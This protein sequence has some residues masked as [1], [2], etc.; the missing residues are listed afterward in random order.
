MLSF[1]LFMLGLIISLRLI[2]VPL[3]VLI[4]E[5]G[6]LVTALIFAKGKV[7]MSLGLPAGSER[8]RSISVGRVTVDFSPYFFFW[9][10][11]S[12]KFDGATP[13]DKNIIISFSG[14][15]ANM[16]VG[17][18]FIGLAFGFDWH[19]A[20]KWLSLVFL[21]S[22]VMDVLI[23][24]WPR[25]HLPNIEYPNIIGND[26]YSIKMLLKSKAIIRKALPG[27]KELLDV[28]PSALAPEIVSA[29]D[30]E[31]YIY[32]VSFLESVS[33]K[34]YADA[35][36]YWS[37][38]VLI[39]P[40]P[41]ADEYLNAGIVKLEL[42]RVEEAL[43]LTQKAYNL[44]TE[45]VNTLNILGYILSITEFYEQAVTYLDK[46]IQIDS[47]FAYAYNNRGYAL[48][49]LGE[50]ESG[51][52]SIKASLALDDKNGYAF[53]NLGIYYLKKNEPATA[54]EYLYTA[55]KLEKDIPLVDDLIS[56]GLENL[57]SNK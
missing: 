26:G 54:L 1:A 28:F 44:N 33:K 32:L 16:F 13:I 3:C 18:V 25:K 45:D 57:N 17:C 4:H 5:L 7:V 39:A 12:V 31:K 51:L 27:K 9:R 49:M 56:K 21:F 34:Q 48:L 2:I 8:K 38:Y 15:L 20:L 53:R 24:L 36:K 19:G 10:S 41:A 47:T 29:E 35:E 40:N 22:A 43:A 11:G 42:N 55:K 14:S 6:H 46:A 50:L 37:K 52:K 30:G 23:N